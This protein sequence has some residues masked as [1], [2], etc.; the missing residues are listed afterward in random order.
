MEGWKSE[1]A[2]GSG[3]QLKTEGLTLDAERG[4]NSGVKD[5]GPALEG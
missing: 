4:V 2:G 5:K 1:G 3:I